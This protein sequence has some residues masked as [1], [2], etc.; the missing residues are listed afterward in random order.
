MGLFDGS[1]STEGCDLSS[2]CI[3]FLVMFVFSGGFSPEI[4]VVL[5]E[6]PAGIFSCCFSVVLNIVRCWISVKKQCERYFTG[7][8]LRTSG[9]SDHWRKSPHCNN[10][11]V[12]ASTLSLKD[13][14][15]SESCIGIK[16]ELNFYFHTFL[17]CFKRF[18]EGL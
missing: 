4:F 5:C 12:L 2:Y 9:E 6:M 14:I 15:I 1:C 17:W 18:Y 7:Y 3:S 16:I 8:L 10:P 11:W 13:P